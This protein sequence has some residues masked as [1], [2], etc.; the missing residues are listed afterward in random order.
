MK[1]AVMQPYFFPYIGYFQLVNA[2]D[3]FVFY[4]DVNYIKNGWINRNRIL[5]NKQPSLITLPLKQASSFR[6]INEIEI[7]GS[8]DK[9]LRSIRMSYSKAPFFKDVFPMIETVLLTK[10]NLISELSI[11]SIKSVCRYLNINTQFEIASREFP[12]IESFDRSDRIISICKSRNASTYLNSIGGI[13]LYDSGYF[14][15]NKIKLQFIKPNITIYDQFDEKF[16]PSLSIIDV[17]MFNDADNVG[18][19][20]NDYTVI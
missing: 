8:K 17:L 9:I 1:I 3:S 15:K 6:L 14:E 2:V 11:E 10:T 20:L 4:D 7:S 19:M 18:R 5:I 12:R 13:D 16:V